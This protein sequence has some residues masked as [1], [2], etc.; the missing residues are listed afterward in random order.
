[1]GKIW[2]K[3]GHNMGKIWAHY[4]Q[5]TMKLFVYKYLLTFSLSNLGTWYKAFK[6]CVDAV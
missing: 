6:F 2:I 5:N 3:Y 4:W 1:M